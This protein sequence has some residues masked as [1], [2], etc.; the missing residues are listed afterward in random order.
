MLAYQ[1]Y[2]PAALTAGYTPNRLSTWPLVLLVTLTTRSA[3]VAQPA[4]ASHFTG[5]ASYLGAD[6]SPQAVP[7]EEAEELLFEETQLPAMPVRSYRVRARIRDI[8][9]GQLHL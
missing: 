9:K 6:Y 4:N 7:S 8:R 3:A 2:N 1:T 5:Q